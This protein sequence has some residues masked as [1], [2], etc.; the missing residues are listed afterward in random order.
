LVPRRGKEKKTK[1]ILLWRKEGKQRE[2][3]RKEKLGKEIKR[4]N[5]TKQ[6]S[7]LPKFFTSPSGMYL[8]LPI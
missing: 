7:F 8:F 6:L 1:G 4:N 5:P 2:G 3:E